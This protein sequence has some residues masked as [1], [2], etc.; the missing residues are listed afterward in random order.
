MFFFKL[1]LPDGTQTLSGVISNLKVN[2]VA[3]FVARI[4]LLNEVTRNLNTPPYLHVLYSVFGFFLF[5]KQ[6]LLVFVQI[7]LQM[8]TKPSPSP[9]RV[10][11]PKERCS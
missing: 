8:R 4:F 7:L 9:P 1:H 3:I 11:Q 2:L 5:G 6:I 10:A